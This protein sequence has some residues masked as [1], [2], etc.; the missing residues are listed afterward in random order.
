[1]LGAAIWRIDEYHLR[2][3]R[4][5]LRVEVSRDVGRLGANLKAN[6]AGNVNLVAGLAA[7]VAIEPDM[8]EHHFNQLASRI[9]EVKSQLRYLSIAPEL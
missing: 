4:D 7:A 3:H 9:L 2:E 1:V 6:I 8:D 5:M